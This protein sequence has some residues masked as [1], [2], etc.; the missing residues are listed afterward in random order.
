MG[1]PFP[2]ASRSQRRYANV[3][4]VNNLS[5]GGSFQV[6]QVPASGWVRG[7]ELLFSQAVTFAS[8]GAVVT[9]DTPWS[10]INNVTVTD[11]TGQPV[12]QPI[13]GFGLYLKNKM[14][15]RSEAVN[16]QGAYG[17][18]MMSPEYAFSSTATDAVAKFRLNL[19]FEV[20]SKSGYGCIPNLDSN[21]SLQIKVDYN[22]H[23]NAFTGTGAS[24]ATLSMRVSQRYWAP[25]GS[26]IGGAPVDNAPPGAGDYLETRYETQTVSAAAEN[27]ITLT[28]R[29]GLIK[30][31]ILVSRAAG[32][33]TAP[34]AGAN[35]GILLDNQPIYEG[36]PI[37]E[38]FDE[39]RRMFGYFGADL[40]TSYA[41]L[42]A[43]VTPG[44]DRG[45]VA[46]QFGGMSGGRDAWLNTRAGSLLQLKFTP[47]A[48]AT[49]VEVY[50]ELMQVKDPASFYNAGA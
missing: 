9:G 38:F 43:G 29:G 47:G 14:S 19:D 31:L 33:R 40:T 12:I 17:N 30:S 27:L 35:F 32:V 1:I 39:T 4:S 8:G 48:S 44:L 22:V 41:P 13:S 16:F 23:T 6:I 5:A 26:S 36:I 24:V 7:F 3:Q 42:T 15:G 34:T 2:V 50:T 20:D 28:N 46:I 11:A 25:V 49:T 45:V 18:P 37:E 21:A 10:L